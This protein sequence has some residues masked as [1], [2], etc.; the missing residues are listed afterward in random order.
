MGASRRT[1]GVLTV[2]DG[3]HHGTREDRSGAALVEVLTEA[4][5]DVVH[6]AVVPDER[7][8]IQKAIRQL[9]RKAALVLT[10]GG[11]GFGPRDVTPEATRTVLEREAPGLAEAM[12]AAG[13]ATTPMANLSR[14]LV[15]TVGNA[16][17]LNLPGSP[18]GAVDSFRSVVDIVPHAL[19]LLAG[20]TEHRQ[21]AVTG[22]PEAT[23]A[24]GGHSHG[25]SHGTRGGAEEPQTR[26]DA[27]GTHVSDPA[28][29]AELNRRVALGEEV[30]LAT[31][32]RV[33]GAPPCRPGQKMLLG[34][35]GPIAG[36]LMCSEFDH[37]ATEDA[38][39]VLSGGNPVLRTYDHD[40]GS[41]DVYLE[42]YR[43]RPRLVVVGATPVGLCLMKWAGEAGYETVLLES[44]PERVTSEH[45]TVAARVA[46]APEDLAVDDQT[47]AVHTD[48]EAPLVA[49]HL[50]ALLKG[51]ARFVGLVGSARHANEHLDELRR[52]GLT[53]QEVAK[54]RT[55][56]GLNLGGRTSQEIAL[57]ILAGLVAARHGRSG[58]WLDERA[59]AAA[60]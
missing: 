44:R 47:D 58:G 55:P 3:V 17:V 31:A 36:T 45:R 13:R 38:P 30:L 39:T 22:E 56:V 52:M 37:A 49:E 35:D 24:S 16:L 40:L 26:A 48:H 46:A 12:R 57:S 6:R 32:V 7:S 1:A 25:D 14:G 20:D 19:D 9:S 28:V 23:A 41:V 42:P 10:T 8:D 59:P 43:R 4:G 11:T 18:K 60:S 27:S 53:D 15:G 5:F 54:V 29:A 33:H 34:K 21:E 51:G 2:S 50:F